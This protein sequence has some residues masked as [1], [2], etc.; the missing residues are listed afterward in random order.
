MANTSI[1][2]IGLR[3]PDPSAGRLFAFRL[4]RF[5]GLKF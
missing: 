1:L 5:D 4:R 3:K 2:R